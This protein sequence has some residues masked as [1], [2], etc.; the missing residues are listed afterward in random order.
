MFSIADI[1]NIAVQ[2]EKNGENT[3]KRASLACKS[4][5]I[6][7]FLASMA[8]DERRHGQWLAT[9]TSN[10]PLTAE[11]QEMEQVGRRLLQ[12]MVKDNPFLLDQ[13]DLEGATD[14]REVLTRSKSFEE[15]TILFYQ[16]IEDLLDD[17]DAV[18][19]MRKIISEERNHLA[20]LELLE[21]HYLAQTKA[22][23]SC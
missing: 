10:K 4:P 18:R 13:G 17:Q 6:A 11:Q 8:E 3:Y 22:P 19:Q 14:I 12:E 7:E 20:Q 21:Q 16:F 1:R 2:I 9:I 23:L 15:D 5:E